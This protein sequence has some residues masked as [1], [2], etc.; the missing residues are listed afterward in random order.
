[1][2]FKFEQREVDHPYTTQAFTNEELIKI[3]S[4]VGY[5]TML[6]CINLAPMLNQTLWQG[7]WHGDWHTDRKECIREG[8]TH[9]Q[10][11]AE[12]NRKQG[13]STLMQDTF[14]KRLQMQLADV[15]TY[16]ATEDDKE[17]DDSDVDCFY[18]DEEG[19]A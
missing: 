4:T 7:H 16:E 17:F 12:A 11:Q 1:M 10:E 19:G 8:I 14:I 3:F 13:D 2:G 6:W 5:S 18:N 15:I 9:Y